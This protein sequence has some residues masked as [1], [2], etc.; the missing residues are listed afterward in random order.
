MTTTLKRPLAAILFAPQFHAAI[1]N[2]EKQITIREG[3]RDYQVG[4]T[5]MLC[6][7]VAGWCRMGTVTGVG[8]AELRDVPIESLQAD[9]FS[10]YEDA[11]V[12]MNQ[13]YPEL[14]LD[15]VVTVIN[16]EVQE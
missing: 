14:T 13:F 5:V 4:E 3:R 8:F 15:S 2:G 1:E 16:F 12:V 11:L 9:G 10:G 7:H 6:C